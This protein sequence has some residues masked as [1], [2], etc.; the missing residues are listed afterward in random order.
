MV[1]STSFS[2][3]FNLFDKNRFYFRILQGDIDK[4]MK[5]LHDTIYWR[6]K[7][8]DRNDTLTLKV[9]IAGCGEYGGHVEKIDI[10][11]KR[12]KFIAL[13]KNFG[14]FSDCPRESVLNK[15]PQ[16]FV[17]ELV[18]DTVK[19]LSKAQINLIDQ[20]IED[21]WKLNF[22]LGIHSNVSKEY[23]VKKGDKEYYREDQT[24][25][26][27]IFELLGDQLFKIDK[28]FIGRPN[29]EKIDTKSRYDN[30]SQ[31]KNKKFNREEAKGYR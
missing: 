27:E 23:W 31:I 21:C 10:I 14:G 5:Y 16:G 19:V 9:Y 22:Q 2:S 13:Y 18:Y 24:S 26:I 6:V 29:D 25:E 15:Y 3:F 4:K 20:Y 11:K 1:S 17:P 7:E 28:S 8:I 12:Q 30:T